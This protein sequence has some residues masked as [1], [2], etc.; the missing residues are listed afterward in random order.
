MDVILQKDV[1]NLGSK[2]DVVKVAEGYGRNYLIPK[3][4][5]IEAT[6]KNMA[7]LKMKKKQQKKREERE[8]QE[9]QNIARKIDDK[10]LVLKVKAGEKGRLFG[11]IT[12]KDIAEKIQSDYGVELDKRKIELAQPIRTLGNYRV[13]IKIHPGVIATLNVVVEKQDE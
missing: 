6:D 11:S 9:A 5:A 3:G 4:L 13:E 8:L 7:E 10:R 12:T 1:K 2:G